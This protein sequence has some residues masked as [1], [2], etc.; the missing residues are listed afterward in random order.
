[1]NGS[2][3]HL[4]PLLIALLLAAGSITPDGLAAQ[5]LQGGLNFAVGLPQGDFDDQVENDAFGVGG[6]F[7]WTPNRSPFGIGISLAFM[8]YGRETR[9]EPF[10]TTIPDVT[11]EV[12]T[13]NNLLNGHIL[14]RSQL[15]RGD[16]RPYGDLLFGFNYFFT[17]TKI[18][19]ADGISEEIASTTNF[20]DAVLS[21]GA[22]GGLLIRVYSGSRNTVFID[23]GARYL[24]GGEAE[25]LEKGS[26]GRDNGVVTFDVTRSETNLLMLQIGVAANF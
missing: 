12:E 24:F 2:K 1:M 23:L 17:E 11:V 14:F 21:Y 16:I 7:L 4:R 9:R 20:D 25:Y 18:Q 22:G 19:D 13:T 26:I 15:P 5:N 6:Q 10:S 8:N 3:S